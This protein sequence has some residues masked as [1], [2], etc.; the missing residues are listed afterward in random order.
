MNCQDVSQP[1]L[2]AWLSGVL[3]K[4]ILCDEGDWR[5]VWGNRKLMQAGPKGVLLAQSACNQHAY[6]ALVL[7]SEDTLLRTR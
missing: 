2:R 4:A 3:Y 7:T 1:N 6:S 5:L